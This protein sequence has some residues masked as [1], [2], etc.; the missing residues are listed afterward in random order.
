M[1]AIDRLIARRLTF[2]TINFLVALLNAD[3]GLFL[4]DFT[5]PP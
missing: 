1:A 5:K 4:I 3:S 2:N